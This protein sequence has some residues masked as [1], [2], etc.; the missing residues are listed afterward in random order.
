M[1]LNYLIQ[2]RCNKTTSLIKDRK[3]VYPL[4]GLLNSKPIIMKYTKNRYFCKK[5]NISF[6]EPTPN[7]A[8]KKQLSNVIFDLIYTQLC[9]KSNYTKIGKLVGVSVSTLMRY[10]DSI[11][12]NN[13]RYS[14]VKH[15]LIDELRLIAYSSKRKLESFSLQLLMLIPVKYLIFSLIEAKRMCQSI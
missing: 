5:C 7:V 3:V 13:T 14:K 15:I 6:T 12:I 11:N 4:V 8:P 1:I 2:K 9:D 10:L